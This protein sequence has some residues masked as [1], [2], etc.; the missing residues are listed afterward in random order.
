[1]AHL[2]RAIQERL[3][4][5][6]P[7]RQ[8]RREVARHLRIV[9]GATQRDTRIEVRSRLEGRALRIIEQAALVDERLEAARAEAIA[10]RDIDRDEVALRFVVASHELRDAVTEQWSHCSSTRCRVHRRLPRRDRGTDVVDQP[11]DLKIEVVGSTRGE[12]LRALERVCEQVDR[13]SIT[14]C[15]PSGECREELVGVQ[16]AQWLHAA[17]GGT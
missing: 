3:D 9:I 11:G 15:R 5:W 10:V 8:R 17:G 6:A 7:R 4:H 14:R 12:K 13:L 2:D 16:P 1:V